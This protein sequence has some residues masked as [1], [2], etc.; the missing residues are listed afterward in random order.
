MLSP[1]IILAIK[2]MSDEALDRAIANIAVTL[3]ILSELGG[4]NADNT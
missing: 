4:E 3:E 1:E 2:Q